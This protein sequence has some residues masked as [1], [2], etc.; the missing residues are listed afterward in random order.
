[1]AFKVHL[2]DEPSG[3]ALRADRR[4]YL[5]AAKAAVVE[6]GDPRAAFLLAGKGG[7]IPAGEAARL[8]L[9]LVDGKVVLKQYDAPVEDKQAAKPAENKA[10]KSKARGS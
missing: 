5:D 4:L 9:S 1:M 3:P 7:E 10:S 6:D 8:G 2:G